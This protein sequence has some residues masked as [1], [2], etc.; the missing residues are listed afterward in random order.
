[1]GS[2]VEINPKAQSVVIAGHVTR[3]VTHSLIP[4]ANCAWISGRT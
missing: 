3:I 4:L 1:M 2:I